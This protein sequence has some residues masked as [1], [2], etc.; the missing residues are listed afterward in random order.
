MS[1]LRILLVDNYDSFTFNLLHMLEE[2]PDVDLTL[3]RNDDDFLPLLEAGE[4]DGV[5]IGPGPGSAEDEAY[6]GRNAEVITGYGPKGLPILGVCLGFQGIF[7]LFGGTLKQAAL[8]VHGKVSALD[9]C[10]DDPILQNVPNGSMVMRYHSIIADPEGGIPDVLEATAY[11]EASEE[12]AA[13]GKEL[14]AFRHRELPIFGVQ[15]HPESFGTNF[16]HTMIDNFCRI[17]AE[18]KAG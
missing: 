8:P 16:G 5:L 4:I 18:R 14:M 3:V 17:V 1:K 9:I 2:R 6:F 11:A 15:F 13:N 10:G 12:F 7:H